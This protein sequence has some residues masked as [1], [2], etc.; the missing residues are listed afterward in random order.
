MLERMHVVWR[1]EDA[2]R[3]HPWHHARSTAATKSIESVCSG[4]CLD[5]IL[6]SGNLESPT[7]S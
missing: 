4:T 7:W 6:G 3:G 2:A 1:L 5:N